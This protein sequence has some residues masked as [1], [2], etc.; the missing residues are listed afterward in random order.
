MNI[1]DDR[2]ELF[3]YPLAR[4]ASIYRLTCCG[5][6]V[7]LKVQQVGASDTRIRE[8]PLTIAGRLHLVPHLLGSAYSMS[9][10]VLGIIRARCF[11]FYRKLVK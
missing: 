6:C 5:H 11:S 3:I 8:A 7:L 1:Q 2:S 9:V 4:E 10:D